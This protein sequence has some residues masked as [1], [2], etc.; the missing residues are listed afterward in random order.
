MRREIFVQI[1]ELC[2]AHDINLL[3]KVTQW[4]TIGRGLGITVP[5]ITFI[6]ETYFVCFGKKVSSSWSV[7]PEM[8]THG[9][10]SN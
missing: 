3:G 4:L 8:V 9:E 5:I 1:L 2:E 6:N 10:K 7:H